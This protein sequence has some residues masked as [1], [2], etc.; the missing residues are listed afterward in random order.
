M[1]KA[2]ITPAFRLVGE[3]RQYVLQRLHI[4]DPTRMPGYK[5]QEGVVVVTREEWRDHG[6]YP[7]NTGGLISAVEYAIINE[8]NEKTE[9]HMLSDLLVEYTRETARL[10]TLIASTLRLAFDGDLGAPLAS[11]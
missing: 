2:I 8:V 9:V 7:L 10:R 3:E 6:Y 11:E 4:V 5:S 1:L